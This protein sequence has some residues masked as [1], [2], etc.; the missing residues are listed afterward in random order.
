MAYHSGMVNDDAFVGQILTRREA[1]ALAGVGL[2]TT[3][4]LG[5]AQKPTKSVNLVA[6]PE[7]TEG[8]FFVDE[9]LNRSD[10]RGGSKRE[11]VAKGLPLHLKVAVFQ[12]VSGA[13][14]PLKGAHVDVWHCDAAGVYSDE[15]GGGMQGETTTGQKWLRG[16]QVTDEK[17]NVAFDTIYPGFYQGRTTHIHFKIRTYSAAGDQTHE[18]T[19]QFFFDDKLSEQVFAQTPYSNSGS[20]PVKNDRDGIFAARQADGTKVGSHLMLDIKDN[21]KGGKVGVFSVALNLAG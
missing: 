5:A 6:T 16:Y 11:A 19:S 8:P 18:F 20:E 12:V 21:P 2:L 3:T 17:G 1:L 10:I 4:A 13:R 9:K 15:E 7:V 14:K